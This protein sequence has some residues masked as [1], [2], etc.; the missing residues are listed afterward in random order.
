MVKE[1]KT[2]QAAEAGHL[3]AVIAAIIARLLDINDQNESHD[4]VE[5]EISTG[6]ES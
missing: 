6:G 5:D 3:L 1:T 4:P 2:V